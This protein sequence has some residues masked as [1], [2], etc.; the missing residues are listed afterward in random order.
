LLLSTLA[1]D[2]SEAAAVPG[3]ARP[4]IL[5]RYA[6]LVLLALALPLFV[7]A[8]LPLL[9]YAVAAAAWLAQH[10]ILAYADRASVAALKRGERNRALGIVGFST[11]A[12]LWLVT[13]AILLVGL[14][15][16]REDGLAAAVLTL[17][18]VTAHLGCLGISKLLYPDAVK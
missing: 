14:L 2:G 16:E 17:A 15:G 9:G 5:L 10:G 3:G 11:L 8:G 12:R 18:L 1:L 6:D 4:G 7:V 13:L